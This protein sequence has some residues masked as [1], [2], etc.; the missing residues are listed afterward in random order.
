MLR[1]WDVVQVKVTP[2]VSRDGRLKF[3]FVHGRVVPWENWR[4][5][6]LTHERPRVV[7]DVAELMSEA[8]ARAEEEREWHAVEIAEEERREQ[9][10]IEDA[11]AEHMRLKAA[12]QGLP[13]SLTIT[14]PPP[15]RP[16]PPA[17]LSPNQPSIMGTAQPVGPPHAMPP[18]AYHHAMLPAMHFQSARTIST[19]APAPAPADVLLP[20]THTGHHNGAVD[21]LLYQAIL[22][23]HRPPQPPQPSHPMPAPL[24]MGAL[25]GA[26]IHTHTHP[27][28]HTHTHILTLPGGPSG[29]QYAADDID[30]ILSSLAPLLHPDVR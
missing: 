29:L 9:R 2:C 21:E 16:P 26:D 14:S 3:T 7:D 8:Q 20:L 6:A 25:L 4:V 10:D 13:A 12:L 28:P 11:M 23:T 15:G 17:N 1:R 22:A 18:G 30:N 19:P 27:H 24:A 5:E